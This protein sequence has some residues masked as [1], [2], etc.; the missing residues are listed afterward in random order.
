M[1]L[2]A[3][4]IVFAPI[5]EIKNKPA[6]LVSVSEHGYYE[7]HMEF[8]GRRHTVLAPILQTGLVFNE[9]EEEFATVGEIER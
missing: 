1:D 3:R 9:P 2:P 5:M 6:T 4:V 8:S 7:L